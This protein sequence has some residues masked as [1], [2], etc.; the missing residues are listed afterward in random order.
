MCSRVEEREGF[1]TWRSG[2]VKR[3]WRSCSYT[4]KY[5]VDEYPVVI[6]KTRQKGAGEARVTMTLDT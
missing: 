1:R 2:C 4:L 5:D 3:T 6:T